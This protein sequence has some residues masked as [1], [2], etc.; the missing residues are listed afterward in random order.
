M[1][2]PGGRVAMLGGFV[3]DTNRLERRYPLANPSIMAE[4]HAGTTRSFWVTIAY[5]MA[6]AVPLLVG[7]G[8]SVPGSP[9]KRFILHR[10][11][12]LH[13]WSLWC[14]CPAPSIRFVA[15]AVIQRRP[16]RRVAH[17]ADHS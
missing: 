8:A 17:T 7:P 6:L 9:R 16:G 14:G 4:L 2:R 3:M 1:A 15:A 5:L 13:R 11:D 10:D 12:G